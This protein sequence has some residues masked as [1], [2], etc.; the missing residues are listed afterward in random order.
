MFHAAG[1]KYGLQVLFFRSE[2]V[3]FN[4][5]R[6][7]AW[8]SS[9][10]H[11]ES[12]WK[13]AW[14]PFP[15]V[16]YENYPVGVKGSGIGAKSVKRRFI[17]LGIP[18]FNP[19]FFNKANL[20]RLLIRSPKVFGYLP[21]SRLAARASDIIRLLQKHG[22]VY[23]K[24]IFGFQGKGILEIRQMGQDQF[25]VRSAKMRE[26]SKADRTLTLR[27]LENFAERLLKNRKYLVQQGLE[28]ISR[29][30]RKIDFRVVVHRGADGKWHSAGIRPKLG[31]PNSIVTNSH[32]GGSKTT[33]QA[34]YNWAHRNHISLPSAAELEK[35]ALAAAR[36]L[37]RYRP[38]LS[39]LGI[40][41]AVDRK[42]GIYLLDFNEI[43]GRDLLTYNM[44]R[45]VTDLTAGFASFLAT[46]PP[47]AS[48][49]ELPMNIH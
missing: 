36:Y 24:P 27:Q 35:P 3:D 44:L 34:L 23:L 7:R 5:R 49:A 17:K 20:H 48:L 2:D 39:H 32:A 26:Q 6:V 19:R 33:W 18:A 1:K 10:D 8:S 16:L 28:L 14:H 42:N 40:D 12:G 11:G 25:Q 45:R 9:T 38:T 21:E 4:R 30:D 41:V 22:F 13:R 37:T 15:D 46:S 31:R 47:T 29:G 43:P